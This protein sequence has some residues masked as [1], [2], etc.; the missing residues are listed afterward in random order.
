MNT[1]RLIETDT[2]IRNSILNILQEQASDLLKKSMPKIQLELKSRFKAALQNEPEYASLKSGK[3]KAELGL[4]ESVSIDR[5]VDIISDSIKMDFSPG[6]ISNRGVKV[7]LGI[8]IFQ[9]DGEPAISSEDA[10]L[11]DQLR[12]YALPWLEWLLFY[13]TKPIVKNYTVRMGSNPYS[14][15][16][17]AIMVEDDS[18]WRVPAEFAGTPTN[19]WVTRA[20]STIDDDIKN[21]LIQTL[22][23]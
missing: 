12:G 21:F 23:G 16:G 6:T 14:R 9:Q 20:L 1:F 13:G 4:P 11:V 22:K 8:R 19:N 17:M 5:I 15:S 10:I 2:Q 18:N 3:L 7:G